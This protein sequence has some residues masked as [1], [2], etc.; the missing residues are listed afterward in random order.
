MHS[1]NTFRLLF[2]IN[3][4]KEN[5]EGAP[6]L[7]RVT[8]NGEKVAINTKRRVPIEH[9]DSSVGFPFSNSEMLEDLCIYLESFRNKA[10]KGFTELSREHDDVT[11]FMIRDYIQGK[12]YGSYTNFLEYWDI[13]NEKVKES[14]D[15][16]YS[17]ALWRKHCRART[18][19]QEYLQ[20]KYRIEEITIKNLKYEIIDGFI[21]YLRVSKGFE[22]NTC[23]RTLKFMKKIT[24]SAIK[25]GWIKR[26]PFDGISLKMEQVDRPY[27]T[28]SEL[29]RMVEKH[30]SIPRLA[31][32]KDLFLFACYT[33][34]AYIDTKQLKKGNLE[35]TSDGM[36]WI[37]IR[38]Q[39]T[40]Q[41]SQIP[42]LEIPK[43]IIDKYVA[44]EE[45]KSEDPV[46]PVL[47]NQKL[48]AYLKEVADLC[49][50]EKKLSFH[51]ARHTFATTV[52]LQNGVSIE[53]VSRMLG[54]SN[55]RTT[56][57]YAKIVDKKIAMDMEAMSVRTNMNLAR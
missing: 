30:F 28:D 51:V 16:G 34:L 20:L 38:R 47:S 23:V 22:H 3:K 26:C 57:H 39:K 13:H 12:I 50:I 53:S 46:L 19:F 14:I 29:E 25:N 54:H 6:I 42:L 49:G 36:W 8:V 52:T 10:Y 21:H 2:I 5:R 7:L 31:L 17:K 40:N 11:P 27:L 9:W 18:I 43:Q 32:V 24:N 45:L 35:Q 15:K 37:K 1:A 56:Q 48:N 4:S 33:G 41:K 55:I 44:L